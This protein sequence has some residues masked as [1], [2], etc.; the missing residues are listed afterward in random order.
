MVPLVCAIPKRNVTPTRIIN[1]L[2]GKAFI[3][4]LAGVPPKTP[5]TIIPNAIPRKP[6]FKSSLTQEIPT[7]ITNARMD[8]KAGSEISNFVTPIFIN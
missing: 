1:R 4:L 2:S 5:P 8:I 7:R 3:I 6:T